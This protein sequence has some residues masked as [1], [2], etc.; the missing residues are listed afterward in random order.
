ME[1][2][3][4]NKYS[5]NELFKFIFPSLI[6]LILFIIP[7][8]SGDG[9]TI[10]I[11]L[12]SNA[13]LSALGSILPQFMVISIGITFIFTIITKLFKPKAILENKFFNNLFN[14]SPLWALIRILGFIF[15]ICALFKIGPEWI[16]SENT[17]GLLLYDLLP[18]LFS[19][20]V[21]A[22]MLLPL[23]LDFGLLEFVGALLTRVMRP[24]FN[25]PGRSSIDC[26][27]SWLGDG[28]IGVLLTS[29]QYEEGYY[30]EREATVI[31]TTFSAVSITFCLAVISQVKLSHMFVPFYLTVC[32]SGI[33]AAIL[34]PRIPPLS[35]KPDTYLNGGESKNSEVLPEGYTPFTWG[36]EKAVAKAK[37]NTDATNFIKNGLKNVLDML[38]GVTPVVMGMGTSALILAEYTPI[39]KWLGVPFIPILNLLKI[40]EATLASQTIIVGFADM[41]LPSVIGG[42]IIQSEMTRFIIACLSVTQL[43]YISEVGGLLLG[44][45]IPITLKDLFIIFLERTLVTLP[46]ITLVA[47]ILF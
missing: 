7:V 43:I 20:F 10:P 39:F 15:I 5:F 44:S 12:L 4:N 30:S 45:K 34:I 31:G 40:P 1:N 24:I 46:I 11:A 19:I 8:K 27:A 38:L 13:V 36:L 42:A 32:L 35:K 28:T 21:F 26:M 25:L 9:I 18:L 22:G 23:L 29:K 6:G 47:H 3:K 37:S 33:V 16:W 41:F 17:G 2:Q 14:V